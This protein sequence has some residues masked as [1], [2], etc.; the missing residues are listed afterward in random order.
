MPKRRLVVVAVAAASLLA[1]RA[2]AAVLASGFLTNAGNYDTFTC[3][4]VSTSPKPVEDVT[5]ELVD[6]SGTSIVS[7]V[8]IA[9]NPDD[10]RTI[11][12]ETGQAGAYC[13]VTG[14]ISKQRTRLTFCNGT[15]AGL[16]CAATINVP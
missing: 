2:E 6:G 16:T 9:L 5:F 11:F 12:W 13:R 14:K 8:G 3:T 15:G 10:P 1:G 4:V 7:F